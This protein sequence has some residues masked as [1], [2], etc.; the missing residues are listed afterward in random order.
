MR[1]APFALSLVASLGMAGSA[2]AQDAMGG[3]DQ[4]YTNEGNVFGKGAWGDGRGTAIPLPSPGPSYGFYYGQ[5]YSGGGSNLF[6]TGFWAAEYSV[7][8]GG[9]QGRPTSMAG[10]PVYADGPL[11]DEVA[12]GYSGYGEGDEGGVGKGGK[13]GHDKGGKGGYDHGGKDKPGKDHGDKGKPPHHDKPMKPPHEGKPPKEIVRYVPY[14]RTRT[15]VVYRRS[16]SV[17][18]ME[19]VEKSELGKL[20]VT[21]QAR[22]ETFSAVCLDGKGNEH[23]AIAVETNGDET[24]DGEVFRCAGDQMLRVSYP[25]DAVTIRGAVRTA[26]GSSYKDCDGGDALV[27]SGEGELMCAPKRSMS[28]AR[29][30]QLAAAGGGSR[31]LAVGSYDGGGGGIDISGLELTGGVGGM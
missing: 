18:V 6:G 26:D 25:S 21:Y 13:G 30:R 22:N 16:A 9:G 27:R 15:V 2:L 4:P 28:P 3:F 20:N 10:D 24:Y 7:R 19:R 29:E 17:V 1:I 5:P 11:G 23:E 31:D 8:A 12:G 14:E